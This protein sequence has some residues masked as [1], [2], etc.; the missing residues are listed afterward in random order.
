MKKFTAFML[1]LVL[2]LPLPL[3]AA[4][5]PVYEHGTPVTVHIDGAFL[6]S[7]VP[8]FIDN[9]RT[10]VPLRAAAEG[11]GASVVWN[12]AAQTATIIKDDN[13]LVFTQNS[14]TYTQNGMSMPL[15]VP[16]Q[17]VESRLFIPLRALGEALGVDVAWEQDMLDVAITTGAPWAETPVIP[18]ALPR[19]AAWLVNKYYVQPSVADPYVGSWYRHDGPE[20]AQTPD[21]HAFIFVSPLYDGNYQVVVFQ[22]SPDSV[23]QKSTLLV[24]NRSGWQEL[25]GLRTN[26][27]GDMLYFFG[28]GIGFA[29]DG[30][31]DY[32]LEGD[33][34]IHTRMIME[35]EGTQTET[36]VYDVFNRI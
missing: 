8:P 28:H 13:T 7:D 4:D 16:L 23:T 21:F 32:I 14:L 20:N 2:L 6:P 9:S 26:F 5:P 1:I 27:H 18:D 19:D 15:D 10:M 3:F 35:M 34:L 36:D 33:T 24:F 29:G 22:A 25:N 11:L 12:S 30:Y 31:M 17:N